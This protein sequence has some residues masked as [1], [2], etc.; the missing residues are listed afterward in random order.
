MAD[1]AHSPLPAVDAGQR[2]IVPLS[3]SCSLVKAVSLLH[4]WSG[5]SLKTRKRRVIIGSLFPFPTDNDAVRFRTIYR[6]LTCCIFP[7]Q[8]DLCS[9]PVPNFPL[10]PSLLKYSTELLLIVVEK[11]RSI[12]ILSGEQRTMMEHGAWSC[13]SR[14]AYIL[15]RH[16]AAFN[17]VLDKNSRAGMRYTL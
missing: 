3:S 10:L 5:E 1:S 7:W 12:V 15:Y 13:R 11:Y 17:N 16:R 14:R 8:D 4:A 2:L 6:T 9:L